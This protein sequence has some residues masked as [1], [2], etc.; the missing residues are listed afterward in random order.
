MQIEI[1]LNRFL[2]FRTDTPSEIKVLK[3]E[4][5]HCTNNGYKGCK[6]VQFDTPTEAE[7]AYKEYVA[8]FGNTLEG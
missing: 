4:F 7:A 3:D 2:T 8:K 5:Q 1:Q 6:I